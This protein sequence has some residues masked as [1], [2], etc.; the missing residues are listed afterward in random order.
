MYRTHTIELWTF[1]VYGSRPRGPDDNQCVFSPVTFLPGNLEGGGGGKEIINARL[2][3]SVSLFLRAKGR[4]KKRLRQTTGIVAVKQHKLQ[5]IR[6]RTFIQ[7]K[8]WHVGWRSFFPVPIRCTCAARGD[9]SAVRGEV[10]R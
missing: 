5:V 9:A 8:A 4:K 3:L 6:L 7:E 2:L 1:D 10:R